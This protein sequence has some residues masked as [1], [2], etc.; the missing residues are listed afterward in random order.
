MTRGAA[1]LFWSASC[2]PPAISRR[3]LLV[4]GGAALAAGV[5]APGLARAAD[6]GAAIIRQ[7]A[8]SPDDPWAVCHGVRAMGRDFT[9]K[10]G[11]RAVDF[12]LET[13]LVS[14]PA[15][16]KSALGF[17]SQVEV[18]QNMFLKTLLEAGVPLDYGFAHQGS[19]R[20]L[21]D[22]V[23]GARALFRPSQVAG[24]PNALP[25]SLIAFARTTSPLKPRWTNAWGEA[26][27]LDV[28][29]EI[30]LR[31]L[32]R[33][34]L[35]LEQ[36]MRANQPETS[37]A[38]VHDFTCG[39]THMIYG[40]L[41]AMQSGYTGKDRLERVRRQVDLLVWRLRADLELIGRFYAARGAEKGVYWYHGDA[42][43]KLLGHVEE[44]LA[45]GIARG[46]VTL[47]AAQQGER[48]AAVAALRR[49]IEDMEQKNMAEAREIDRELFQQ[50]VGDVCHA[51]HGLAFA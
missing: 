34:S 37:K 1:R 51:H 4:G 16:G 14:L 36:T 25:W 6:D 32:E 45:F 49:M 27:E 40:L 23:E 20:T 33:A 19:R 48:R 43:V 11:R 22:V 28:V 42:K 38:P 41:A 2:D 15:N 17:P 31:L 8:T 7:H 26:V 44:C 21:R 10:N 18:H 5:V 35:P 9:L 46:I 13:Q 29:V 30:A 39:G 47:T 24:T 12:L 50:L 3:Q